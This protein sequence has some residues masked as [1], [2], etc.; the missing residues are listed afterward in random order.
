MAQPRNNQPPNNTRIAKADLCLSW[1][2]VYI[3]IFSTYLHEESYKGVTITR[4]KICLSP[5]YSSSQQPV[6][7]R[8]SVHKKILVLCISTIEC[9]NGCKAF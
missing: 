9:G 6:L 7:Y 3:N 4:K 1:M 5:T 8:P 2:H